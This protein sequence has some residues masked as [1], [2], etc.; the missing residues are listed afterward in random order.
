[1][2]DNPLHTLKPHP[3]KPLC[4]VQIDASMLARI[5]Q[6]QVAALAALA[7]MSRKDA[8]LSGE[9]WMS[10]L[11]PIAEQLLLLRQMLDNGL[12]SAENR[13]MRLEY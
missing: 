10:L 7:G 3:P 8:M 5:C 13:L 2:T 11:D 12:G 9:E 1:M 6:E 4:V